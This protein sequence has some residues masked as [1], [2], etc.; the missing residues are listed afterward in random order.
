[1]RK[2][3]LIRKNMVQSVKNERNIL[4]MAN[5]PFVVSSACPAPGLVAQT[6]GMKGMHLS[7]MPAC[8]LL[9]GHADQAHPAV[10]PNPAGPTYPLPPHPHRTPHPTPRC[11]STTPSP[12]GTT[13][14]S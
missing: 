6:N 14:T 5:N 2:V 10:R 9:Y 13:C 7:A 3:D 4:A 1:M 12:R 8:I 11:A